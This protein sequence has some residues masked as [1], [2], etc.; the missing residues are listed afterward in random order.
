MINFDSIHKGPSLKKLPVPGKTLPEIFLK[1][2]AKY[3]PDRAALRYKS[4]STWK[5]HSWKDYLNNVEKIAGGL[6]KLGIKPL[7]KICLISTNCPEWLF[8]SLAVQ[9]LGASLVPI[10]PNSTP[11]QA[12]YVVEHSEAKLLF[13]QNL[14]Q[15]SK[16]DNWRNALKNLK[17]TIL[18]FG[19]PPTEVIKYEQLITLGTEQQNKAPGFLKDQIDRLKPDSPGG[20][21]YTS[22]TTGPPKG[23]ILTQ[24]NLVFMAASLLTRYDY[25]YED[26]TISFLPLSHIAEQVQSICAGIIAAFTVSFAQSLE[27]I[28][29]DLAEVRPTLFFSVPRL[30]EKV[31]STILE[32]VST[33]PFVKR[34]LFNW[35][36]GVGEKIRQYR[37]SNK[38]IPF[39]TGK[40]WNLANKI[41]FS[42]LKN[43]LGLDR[44]RFF[45]SG[46]APLPAEVSRFFGA[47]GMDI[48]EFFGQTECTGVCNSTDPGKTIPGAVGP[49]I[50]GCEVAIA[51]DGEII[52]RG[53]NVFSGYWKDKHATNEALKDDWLYT[54]DIGFFDEEE[55]IHITDRKKD[56]IVTAGGKNVAPQNIENQLKLYQGISQ[57]VVIGDKR[58][59]L[60][61]LLTIDTA[62]LPKLCEQLGID[63]LTSEQA[64]DNELIIN[65]FQEY[66]DKVNADLAQF[67]TIKY[68]RILPNDFSVETGEL[69]PTLKVKR[70]V[71]NEKYKEIIDSMY[72]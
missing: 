26:Y 9:S 42:K 53:D 71:I 4:D 51:E 54:G 3:G 33:S 67:E 62:S 65:K 63:V 39:V 6:I 37:N 27:T 7:D 35:A 56:I 8:I 12:K 58:K 24:K 29:D 69:T 18:M 40:K 68:F 36:L 34:S 47:M 23:V 43:K 49:P 13:V 44:A 32:T 70:R 15:L 10:Y 28:K 38:T 52:T 61:C 64:V 72:M 1:Q 2:V 59:H 5:E 16:T 25:I 21:I 17:K 19:E 45:G 60:T 66:V 46:A 50:P 20:I 41:V 57:V 14:E 22:G 55:Y 11:D 48:F 30:Y 31:H